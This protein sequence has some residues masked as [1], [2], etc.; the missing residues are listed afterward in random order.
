VPNDL[1]R[2]GCAIPFNAVI[3]FGAATA[4]VSLVGLLDRKNPRS[5]FSDFFSQVVMSNITPPEN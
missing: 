2:E 3:G 1:P 5:Q 4:K